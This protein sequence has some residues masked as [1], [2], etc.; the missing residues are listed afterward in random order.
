MCNVRVGLLKKRSAPNINPILTLCLKNIMNKT[1]QNT[2]FN[3]GSLGSR[4][5]EERSEMRY[6]MWIAE[7]SESSNLW[8]HIAL[9][10]IPKSMLVWVSVNTSKPFFVKRPW[11]WAIPTLFLQEKWRVAWNAGA[12]GH[13]PELKAYSF[14]P[15]KRIIT[16]AA[17]NIKGVWPFWLTDAGFSQ[18]S[19]KAFVKL[20]LKS[21][22]T[23]RWT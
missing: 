11:T 8:T 15:V 10:G 13:S 16:F 4:I 7:F 3:N 6:V 19:S 2:T 12:A 17:A 14:S 18:E 9:F 21:S 1:I 5:D 22:K 20:D 23:T